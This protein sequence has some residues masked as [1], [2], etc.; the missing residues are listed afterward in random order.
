MKEISIFIA[1]H[2]LAQATEILQKHNVGG[3]NQHNYQA[4][5]FE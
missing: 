4:I 2:D 3:N 1:T 5:F